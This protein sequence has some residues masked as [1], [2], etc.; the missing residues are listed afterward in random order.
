MGSGTIYIHAEGLQI[1]EVPR[2]QNESIWNR[3]IHNLE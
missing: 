3:L 2:K 1:S